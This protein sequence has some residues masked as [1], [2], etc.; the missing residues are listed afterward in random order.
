MSRSS[1]V[2]KVRGPLLAAA[3]MAA[4]FAWSGRAHADTFVDP[5]RGF[6]GTVRVDTAVTAAQRNAEVYGAVS[7]LDRMIRRHGLK[8]PMTIGAEF[9]WIWSVAQIP[10]CNTKNALEG[11][12]CNGEYRLQ[13]IDLVGSNIAF[14]LC[15]KDRDFQYCGFGANSVTATLASGPGS[16]FGDNLTWGL[17]GYAWGP[18]VGWANLLGLEWRKGMNAIQGSGVVG[19]SGSYSDWVTFRAGYIGATYSRG[20]YANLSVDKIKAFSTVAATEGFKR[21]PALLAGFDQL[22]LDNIGATSLYL[23]RLLYAPGVLDNVPNPSSGEFDFTTVHLEQISI[24]RAVDVVGAYTVRPEPALHQAIVSLH[25]EA[26]HVPVTS[27]GQLAYSEEGSFGYAI[28]AGVVGLPK[29]PYWGVPGGNAF[30]FNIEAG[31]A[32]P[33]FQARMT[34]RR[35]DPEILAL[36]PFAQGA[37]NFHY[38]L[39]F[40]EFPGSK[41]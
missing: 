33:W 21:L 26:W 28:S 5:F 19:V 29:M 10:G 9:N 38:Y 17:A 7:A 8:S 20:A 15:G 40:T 37:W 24:A 18:T 36:F 11:Q 23:R 4:T 31:A 2:R 34:L 12:Q 14:Q 1:L 32:L 22:Y 25:N 39:S 41:K 35:N 13:N 27:G 30:Y 3:S 6:D 16:R